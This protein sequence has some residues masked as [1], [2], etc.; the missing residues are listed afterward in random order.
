[1]NTLREPNEK[2]EAPPAESL[3]APEVDINSVG[4]SEKAFPIWIFIA[5]ALVLMAL[6]AGMVFFVKNSAPFLTTAKK[7]DIPSVDADPTAST[8]KLKP[9]E[10]TI[11]AAPPVIPNTPK[12]QEIAP[13][14]S[15]TATASGSGSVSGSGPCPKTLLIGPD[16]KPVLDASGVPMAVD[17]KGVYAPSRAANST[18][19]IVPAAQ[20]GAAIASIQDTTD[21]YH[22]EIIIA[23]QSKPPNSSATPN[24]SPQNTF[25]ALPSPPPGAAEILKQIEALQRGPQITAAPPYSNPILS[26][27]PTGPKNGAGNTQGNPNAMLGADKTDRVFAART[28]D[29]NTVIPKGTPIDCSLRTRLVTE[30]SGFAECQVTRDVYSANGRTLLIERMSIVDGEYAA[31]GVAGQRYI[32][33]LWTRLRKP[34][35]ITIDLASPSTD[36][37]GGAGIPATVDNRW[38]ERLSGAYMLSFMKDAIAYETAKNAQTGASVAGATAYQNTRQT[39]EDMASKVLSTTIGIKPVLYVNQGD[40]VG[41]YVARDLDFS[42]VYEVNTR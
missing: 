39:S 6:L 2:E 14:A 37:L 35:G 25:P 41:I 32:H 20:S 29:E 27:A 18:A 16:K 11:I 31:V 5:G 34:R 33:V 19:A 7:E 21:R 36:G 9:A 10:P 24:A 26:S 28:I 4:A 13:S 12:T 22:G 17:C 3:D 42:K 8:P 15:A 30:I 38:V 1:M 40:R 23:K